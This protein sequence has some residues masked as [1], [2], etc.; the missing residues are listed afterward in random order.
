MAMFNEQS[1]LLMIIMDV[2]VVL[3]LS[4][5]VL[6]AG[7]RYF[8]GMG[9]K[10]TRWETIP[11]AF[12]TGV[13]MSCVLSVLMTFVEVLFP[14]IMEDYSQTMDSTYNMGQIVLYLLAGVIGAPLVEELIFRHFMAGELTKGAPRWLTILLTSLAFGIVHGH[15]VQMIYAGL[16][17]ILLASLYFAYDS[18]LPSIALHAG[19]NAVSLLS[20]VDDSSWSEATRNRFDSIVTI[21]VFAFCVI[22]IA[23]VIWLFV[24]RQHWV[25]KK[26]LTVEPAEAVEEAEGGESR[27]TAVAWDSLLETPRAEGS[28]PTVAD[29]SANMKKKAEAEH[30]VDAGSEE[31]KPEDVSAE[32]PIAP[33]VTEK[34]TAFPSEEVGE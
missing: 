27:P 3:A 29:L 2:V 5:I 11:V 8:Q 15:I 32:A 26:E 4:V 18:V 19:F 33:A 17:G 9:V 24:R 31:K 13:G 21:C 16:L 23:G 7:K 25:W 12:F 20:M 10:K 14:K 6:A 1:N 30:A 34:K 22:G 28:F